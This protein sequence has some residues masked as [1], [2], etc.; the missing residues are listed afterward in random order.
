VEGRAVRTSCIALA[1]AAPY[2]PFVAGAVPRFD[3]LGVLLVGAAAIGAPGAAA[4]LATGARKAVDACAAFL[5][6]AWVLNLAAMI[7]RKVL[8]LPLTAAAFAAVLG[9]AAVALGA[10]GAYRRASP[11]LS[12]RAAV[13]GAIA[14]GGF[15]ASFASARWIVPPLQD[16]DMDAQDTAYGL[17]VELTPFGLTD[18]ST[19]YFFAHPL[20]L[21]YFN[22]STLTLAGEI[23]TVRPP[24]DAAVRER[25][26]VPPGERRP[27]LAR[28]LRALGLDQRPP[29][30]GMRWTQRVYGAFR[31][32]PA[33]FGT[34]APNAAF[35]A[36]L[37]ALLFVALGRLGLPARD[38][39]LVTV[40]STTLP[41]IVV[42]SGYG[43]YF[44]PSALTMLLAACA[45]ADPA[46]GRP[47]RLAA[48]FLAMFTNQKSVMVGA[49]AALSGIAERLRVVGAGARGA[50]PL[51]AGM[52]VAAAAYALLGLWIAPE[53]WV[54]DGLLEHGIWRFTA[55]EGA[56]Y[57]S[58]LAYPSPGGLWRDF[59]S[60]MGWPWTA[61]VAAGL[62]RALA[63]LRTPDRDERR[64]RLLGIAALWAVVGGLLFTATDWRQ[65]KHL[66]NLLPAFAL[67]LGGLLARS[68]GPA[69]IAIRV[70]LVASLGWTAVR[71]VQLARDFTSFPVRPIW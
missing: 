19:L 47:T 38:A 46:T 61:L 58:R 51:V 12:R 43:G 40:A 8:A 32:S 71:V 30:R 55:A 54:L 21:H 3:A 68:P 10:A 13:A 2:V 57:A 7:A 1:L 63:T 45:V 34:R 62:L 35:T 49:A 15:L 28:S 56:A 53:D 22:A 33:L 50:L 16:H 9:V 41:E 20:Y 25:H 18:R 39:A 66:C 65:T 36:A 64:G 44:A 29:D 67:L 6:G 24:Y 31:E 70:V 5:L 26:R 11:R 4:V 42:R 60:Q 69:R 14:A 48:G 23:E 59:A 17:M 52:S 27:S 37:W